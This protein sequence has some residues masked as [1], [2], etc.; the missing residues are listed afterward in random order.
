MY[1][2]EPPDSSGHRVQRTYPPDK[3]E[4]LVSVNGPINRKGGRVARDTA[5]DFFLL[6]GRFLHFGFR[7]RGLCGW[8]PVFLNKASK[9]TT[10]QD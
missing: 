10:F 5:S 2:E 8:L 6:W 3:L 4:A 9:V 7:W 1:G